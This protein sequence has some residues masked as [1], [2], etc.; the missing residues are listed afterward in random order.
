LSKGRYRMKVDED[1]VV[2][3]EVVPEEPQKEETVEESEVSQ[4]SEP[5]II[6]DEEEDE[7]DRIV[8]IGDSEPDKE[9]EENQET[10]GWVKKVRKVNRKL[11]SENK[12]LKRQLEENAKAAETKKP[13]ELGE[14][15]T[16]AKCKYDDDK[17]K[18]DLRAY[19][20]RKRKVEEQ[21]SEKAK[22]IENQNKMWQSKQEK[23]TNLKKEHGFKD[24]GDTEE[25]VSNTFSQTQQGIMVQG[26][27]DAALLVYAL[28]K[29]PKKLEELAK[30][31]DPVD[32]AF[33]IAK[34]ESQLKVTTKKA[35]TPE[36]RVPT[37]NAGGMSGTTD[38]TLA[39]LREEAVKTGDYTKVSAYKNKLRKG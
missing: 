37:G 12:K 36:K 31:T 3:E 7:E 26:A 4:E 35:P 2:E 1:L 30:I 29:N 38:N 18:Q 32:F 39:R 28:G 19:D 24:F 8:T 13:V 22:T 34:L 33:K 6:P 25:L 9:S 17:Y 23:Y 20:E 11:E 16:L 15:P 5:V 21:A 27:D 14:E 10:P